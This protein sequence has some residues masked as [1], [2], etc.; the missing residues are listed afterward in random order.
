VD[1]PEPSLGPAGG[2]LAAMAAHPAER[3]L[4]I[5]VDLPGLETTTLE[6]LLDH[7]ESGSVVTAFRSPGDGRVEPLCALYPPSARSTI[8]TS[9][10]AGE[11]SLR[12]ILERS[13]RL[14]LIDPAHPAELIDLDTPDALA[15]LA[16]RPE[17][18][19][20]QPIIH[21]H[22]RYFALL[23]EQRGL[24]EESLTTTHST[25]AGL[26]DDLRQTH[27]LS[28]PRENLQVAIND[29][30]M[31]WNSLLKDGDRVVFL[32]PMAGG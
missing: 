22:I 16:L 17:P 32:P 2:L 3:L 30:F 20:A 25:P 18:T 14:R 1:D 5:A 6:H 23:R 28:L 8:E 21:L 4:V 27:N 31:P 29:E 10:A 13:G 11:L 7:G 9:V 19:V 12:R 15:N 24:S 26:Y